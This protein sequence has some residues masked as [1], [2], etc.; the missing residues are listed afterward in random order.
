VSPS[1]HATRFQ[2]R[3]G[4][5]ARLAVTVRNS[6]DAVRMASGDGHLPRR[7]LGLD[8]DTPLVVFSSRIDSQKRPLDAVRIFASA[9]EAAP[10]A[11]LAV[12][13]RGELEGEVRA[14]AERLGVG[15]RVR[16]VG[17][18]TNIPDWLAAATVWILPTERENFSVAVLEAMAAG[19]PVLSTSCPGND[20]VLIDGTNALT[21]AVGDVDAGA[22]G[23]RTLLGDGLLREKIGRAAETTARELS[24]DSMVESYRTLYSRH[25]D[26]P[27]CLR[28]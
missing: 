20:E 6:I 25:P 8:E 18:Q 7:F 19:C 11:V 21:F 1:E 22:A 12:V 13:G 27:A 2:V 4:I 15:D 17:Y 10:S 5:P 26:A 14:E 24:V 23:L 16:M 28:D 9:T 3:C